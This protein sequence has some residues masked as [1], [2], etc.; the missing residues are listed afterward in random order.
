MDIDIV[1]KD[2][3]CIKV[4]LDKRNTLTNTS[5]QAEIADLAK[6][7]E[8]FFANGGIV[9][10]LPACTMTDNCIEVIGNSSN[11][12]YTKKDFARRLEDRATSKRKITIH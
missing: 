2:Q 11:K 9:E 10:V 4:R 8:E 7:V 6:A 3:E 1:W 12:Q 5:R